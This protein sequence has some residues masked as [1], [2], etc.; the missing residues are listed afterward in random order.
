MQDQKHDKSTKLLWLDL[1]MTGLNPE[2]DRILEVAAIITDFNFNEFARYQSF[3][4]QTPEVMA[5]MNAENLSMHTA[6]GLVERIKV[7]PNEQHV[8]SELEALV[9]QYF[10]GEPA[11]LAG[12]SIHQDRRFIRHWWQPVEQLLHY[13]MLDVSSYKIIMQNKYNIRYPKSESHQALEDILES[14]AE[15]RYYLEGA[16][17]QTTDQQV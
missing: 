7:A 3:V 1:E 2:T 16:G 5:T 13:R 11:I 9:Q 15:L 10:N 8:V 4:Y 6:S 17:A 12:N 14:I